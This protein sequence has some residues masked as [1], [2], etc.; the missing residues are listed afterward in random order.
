MAKIEDKDL[1]DI[2]ALLEDAQTKLNDLQ[3][4][5]KD[6]SEGLRKTLNVWGT[7]ET[8]L[9]QKVKNKQAEILTILGKLRKK[10]NGEDLRGIGT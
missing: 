7:L 5:E 9:K 6:I 3:V 8:E 2:L 1:V 4:Q 10:G